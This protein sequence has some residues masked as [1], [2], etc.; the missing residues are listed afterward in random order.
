MPTSGADWREFLVRL[1]PPSRRGHSGGVGDD[2]RMPMGRHVI[3]LDAGAE[4][5]EE[6]LRV[7]DQAYDKAM[8]V[9]MDVANSELER[10]EALRV[11]T[12][13]RAEAL[14]AATVAR[15]DALRRISGEH[16]DSVRGAE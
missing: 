11:A 1:D 16:I 8:H 7:A 14:R 6:A 3:P 15:A 9:T 10:A 12:L 2:G 13:A 5:E 4:A